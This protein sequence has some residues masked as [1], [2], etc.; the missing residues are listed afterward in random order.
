LER[1][2]DEQAGDKLKLEKIKLHEQMANQVEKRW[3]RTNPERVK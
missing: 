1:K 2:N 3:E